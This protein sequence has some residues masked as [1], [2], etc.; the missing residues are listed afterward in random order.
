QGAN[1]GGFGAFGGQIGVNI[2][3]F[4]GVPPNF[5]GGQV[6]AIGFQ[7]GANLGGGQVGLLGGGAGM[8]GGNPAA[9]RPPLPEDPP[10]VQQPRQPRD[11]VVFGDKLTGKELKA[12]VAEMKRQN[13]PGLL[14]EGMEL[15]D[16]DLAELKGVPG[17]RNLLIHGAHPVAL[18]PGAGAEEPPAPAS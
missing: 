11:A 13:V 7:G 5:G 2:G 3:G 17:L 14:V 9:R 1:V 12:L 18:A 16:A 15:T 8:N 10:R 6:G 4:G